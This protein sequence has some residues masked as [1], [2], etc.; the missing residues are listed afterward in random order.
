MLYPDNTILF[1]PCTFDNPTNRGMGKVSLQGAWPKAIELLQPQR[2]TL[3]LLRHLFSVVVCT[4]GS[5]AS[6]LVM[7]VPPLPLAQALSECLFFFDF[8]SSMA[9]LWFRRRAIPLWKEVRSIAEATMEKEVDARI[10]SNS[11]TT[12]TLR[13]PLPDNGGPLADSS[14][15]IPRSIDR[16]WRMIPGDGRIVGK[17][18]AKADSRP[19]ADLLPQKSSDKIPNF[20]LQ[21]G[22]PFARDPKNPR[23]GHG[24]PEPN[25]AFKFGDHDVQHNAGDNIPNELEV[26]RNAG[27][28]ILNE[29]EVQCT[30]GGSIPNEREAQ[31]HA[32]GNI[33]NELEVQ[34]D[35]GGNVPN[36]LEV[37]RNAGG[38]ILNELEVQHNARGNISN[39]LA[40]SPAP[41]RGGSHW[42]YA[43]GE[44]TDLFPSKRPVFGCVKDGFDVIMKISNTPT[45]CRDSP[46]DP[47]GGFK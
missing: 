12:P 20:M 29:L 24:D 18:N 31:R 10:V 23:S 8:I 35:A 15:S 27:G 2:S 37:R 44:N 43:T 42:C 34:H 38:D 28:N 4:V 25:S 11:L 22:Y 16:R 47:G 45:D 26:Q 33:P 6:C 40:T 9:E 17:A 19:H 3:L 13:Q 5:T 7:A 46:Q 36:E 30:A 39:E 41:C 32:G 1:V 14:K 21:F